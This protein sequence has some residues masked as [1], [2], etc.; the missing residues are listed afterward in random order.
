HPSSAAKPGSGVHAPTGA[1][2]TFIAVVPAIA[3]SDAVI[4]VVP[5]ASASASPVAEIVATA[6][7]DDAHA[8]WFVMFA[9]ELSVNVPVAVNGKSALSG[10]V[11]AP[12]VIAIDCSAAAAT[13]SCAVLEIAP[14]FAVIVAVPVPTVVAT[15]ALVIVATVRSDEVH[16]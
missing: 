13:I 6:W 12:G 15:P 4:V 1:R 14:S 11:G 3:P 9:V 2:T 8:T 5:V 10:T 7:S 16:M